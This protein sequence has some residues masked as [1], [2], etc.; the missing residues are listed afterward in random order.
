MASRTLS[1]TQL[2]L[3][4]GRFRVL[5][6]PTRLRILSALRNRELN[7]T[8]LVRETGFTQANLSKHL[9]LLLHLGFVERR[10]EGL[11]SYYRLAD[12]DVFRLCDIMCGRVEKE[13]KAQRKAW[14]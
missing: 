6:E 14:A 5:G 10:K 3:I 7:V 11:N 4:A 1:A 12:R 8:A 9:Q 2:D 13:L